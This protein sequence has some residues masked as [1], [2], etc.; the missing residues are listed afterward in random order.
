MGSVTLTAW[1]PV[2]TSNILW[3]PVVITHKILFCSQ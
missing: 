1:R 3:I 2:G